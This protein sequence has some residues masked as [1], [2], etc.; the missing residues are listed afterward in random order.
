[1]VQIQWLCD[2][3]VD[4]FDAMKIQLCSSM[5]FDGAGVKARVFN[6][7]HFVDPTENPSSGGGPHGPTFRTPGWART[8]SY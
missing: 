1:M 3:S 7:C 6:L 8:L 5:K 2:W 4:N